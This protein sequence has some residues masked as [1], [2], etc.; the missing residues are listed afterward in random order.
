MNDRSKRTFDV[1]LA[2]Y[3]GFGNLGDELLAEASVG[4]LTASGVE[5][6]RIAILSSTPEESE[7]RLRIRAFDRWRFPDVSSAIT[8]SNSL[9][10]GG[11][12][13]F[14]DSSSR[15]SCLYYWALVRLACFKNCRVWALGQSVG[16]L[17]SKFSRLLTRDA[18]SRCSYLAVR[19][20]VSSELLGSMGINSVEMPDIVM[21][22]TVQDP[23]RTELSSVLINIRPL[24]SDSRYADVVM[25]AARSCVESGTK[26][27]CVALSP[28]DARAM[29]CYMT[30]G[31]MPECEIVTVGSLADFIAVSQDAAAAIGMRLHFGVLSTICG[32]R[33]LLSPYDPKVSGFAEKW[34]ISLLDESFAAKDVLSVLN[35]ANLPD[36]A[37][38]NVAQMHIL[39]CFK[40]GLKI[41]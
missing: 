31:E 11:G 12:G 9:L 22:L 24:Q 40:E 19:D 3:Y 38:I 4:F 37:R 8:Q 29:H 18:L 33:V 27:K 23:P 10:F 2:G 36:R 34:G 5:R 30:S 16:P 28:E 32:L 26:I 35:K 13:L 15:R 41:V 25:K 7:S 21:G 39:G 1:L 6:E 20:T 17:R 14:Q